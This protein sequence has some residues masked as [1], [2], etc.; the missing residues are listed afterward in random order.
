MQPGNTVD[1]KVSGAPGAQ[2]L[3]FSKAFARGV[4][5]LRPSADASTLQGFPTVRNVPP[6]TYTVS[7]QVPGGA[8][9]AVA[10]LKVAAPESVTVAKLTRHGDSTSR[11]RPGDTVDV[12]VSG[13]SGARALAFSKAF[14][15]GVA[16]LRPSAD[17]PTLQ[18]FPTVRNVPPGTYTV[19]VQTADG[20]V[21][22]TFRVR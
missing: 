16:V 22:T 20:T 6:G 19:R 21:T 4:A 12:K 1:V 15:R 11:V 7:V 8:R 2:G 17:A 5:V 10:S 13:A 18:G 9:A 3:A 14:A